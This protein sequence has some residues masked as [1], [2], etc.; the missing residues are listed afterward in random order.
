MPKFSILKKKEKLYI[1]HNPKEG[2]LTNDKK[3]FPFPHVGKYPV[4]PSP[5]NS[6]FVI[7][8]VYLKKA[9]ALKL[10]YPHSHF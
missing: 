1:A 7:K 5:I 4:N 8:D 6:T 3:A 10:S 2:L 9:L